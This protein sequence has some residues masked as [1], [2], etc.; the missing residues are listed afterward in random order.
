MMMIGYSGFV[1][2]VKFVYCARKQNV[3]LL[4]LTHFSATTSSYTVRW[5]KPIAL[6]QSCH[7]QCER[8]N[9]DRNVYWLY[10]DKN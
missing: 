6:L 8:Q 9:L 10:I 2:D 3:Q 4:F 7:C 5:S 1:D